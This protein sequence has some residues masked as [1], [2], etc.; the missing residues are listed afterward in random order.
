[1][2]RG[3]LTR[4]HRHD[5]ETC[6]GGKSAW[7]DPGAVHLAG[8]EGRL[9]D[10]DCANGLRYGGHSGAPGPLG[11]LTGGPPPPPV[12]SADSERTGLGGWNGHARSLLNGSVHR[13]LTS[14]GG[15]EERAWSIPYH[16]EEIATHDMTVPPILHL[17]YAKTYWRRIYE[18]DI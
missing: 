17:R 8:H 16:K 11:D 10:S 7:A 18:M 6:G 15:R 2:V 13:Q 3:R 9:A 12:G 14:L 4:C 1:V 5:I